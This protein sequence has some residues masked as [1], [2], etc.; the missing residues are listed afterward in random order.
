[1]FFLFVLFFANGFFFFRY[2]RLSCDH[3][4]KLKKK[5]AM[6]EEE[7]KK[8]KK[9]DGKGKRKA[10]EDDD[11]TDDGSRKRRRTGVER[12]ESEWRMRI[13][14]LVREM[15]AR[16]DGREE[17]TEWVTGW[18]ERMEAVEVLR[19]GRET[20]QR[21]R[22]RRAE[23][24][25]RATLELLRGMAETQ[26]EVAEVVRGMAATQRLVAERLGR[27][28]EL[29]EESDE[30]EDADG[31]KDEEMTVEKEVGRGTEETEE[32][33]EAEKDVTMG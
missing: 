22:E 15:A 30:E 26:R 27:L 28:I 32:N 7:S 29:G 23:E 2:G 1:L 31:E 33:G 24:I 12:E 14:E 20:E 6:T 10:T 4:T 21:E 18:M 13:E 16:D 3:C 17:T 8:K 9:T 19:E 5:C 11:E 25:S